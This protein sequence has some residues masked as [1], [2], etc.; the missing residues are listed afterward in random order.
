MDVF[1]TLMRTRNLTTSW[2]HVGA[3]NLVEVEF[4]KHKD[5]VKAWKEYLNCLGE[6]FPPNEEKERQD[7]LD[8]KRVTLLTKLL[9]EI[10]K[11]LKIEIAQLDIL[12]GNYVPQGWQ[13]DHV[14]ERIVRFLL[15]N[16][17]SG[18]TSIKIDPYPHQPASAYPPPPEPTT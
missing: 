11:T 13:D 5:V 14:D 17:L 6:P 8:K 7:K 1:R 4:A 16:V 3:L 10:A 12:A 9:D 15:M 18:K 2:D